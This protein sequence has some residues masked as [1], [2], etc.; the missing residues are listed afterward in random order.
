MS[1]ARILAD[2]QVKSA[3]VARVVIFLLSFFLSAIGELYV[4]AVIGK[5]N[6]ARSR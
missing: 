6:L 1:G 5:G 2:L 4:Y 3:R